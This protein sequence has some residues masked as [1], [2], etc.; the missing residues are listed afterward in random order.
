MSFILDSLLFHINIFLVIVGVHFVHDSVR[1]KSVALAQVTDTLEIS[2]I[3]MPHICSGIELL[4]LILMNV[5]V[6][7]CH[8]LEFPKPKLQFT[9]TRSK[10]HDLPMLY[11]QSLLKDVSDVGP[12][13]RSHKTAEHNGSKE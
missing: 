3:K 10:V 12:F 5:N 1:S 13:V 9:T 11:L 2:H 7:R 4:E 6:M 8:Q